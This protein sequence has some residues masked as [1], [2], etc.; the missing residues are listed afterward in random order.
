M[1]L[2]NVLPAP[3]GLFQTMN[4]LHPFPWAD[5]ISHEQMDFTFRET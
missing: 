2:Y 1:K 5:E 3:G 4:T